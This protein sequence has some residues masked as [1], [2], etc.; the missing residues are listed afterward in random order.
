MVFNG[1]TVTSAGSA[2]YDVMGNGGTT[3]LGSA[4]SVGHDLTVNAGTFTTSASNY[5]LTIAGRLSIVGT[6]KLN[7]SVVSVGGDVTLSGTFNAGTSTVTMNGSGGQALGGPSAMTFYNLTANDPAG[8]SLAANLTVSNVLMLSSGPI[9]VG[10]HTLTISNPLGGTITNLVADGTSS[11]TVLGASPGIVVPSSVVQLAAL[12]VNN[13]NGVG[14]QANLDILGTLTLT[15]GP[16]TTAAF[17]LRVDVAGTV[18]R[19]AG[20]VNGYLQ[21]HV[22]TGA[23]VTVT[24]EIGDAASYTPVTVAF[25]VVT[26]AG[27]L[28][29]NTTPG[30]HPMIATSGLAPTRDVNRFWTLTNSGIA[31]DTY[32]ATFSFVATDVDAGANTAAFVVAKF[33]PGGWTLPAVGTRT[34]VTTQATGMTSFSDFA[35]G[36]GTADLGVTIDDGQTSVTAGTGGHA[37]TIT[38]TNGGPS[39][40][41][42]ASLSVT[43]PAG[44]SQGAVS[45][46]QGT[47][48]PVGAGPDLTCALGG[49]AAGAS[50]TVTI[51]YSVPAA[52]PAG[53][54]TAAVAVSGPTADLDGANDAASDATDVVTAADL[55]V[56][57]TD[58]L[59]SVAAGTGGYG[60]TIT[61]TNGGP[62]DA[63][64][65]T[66][67][68][69]WPAGF[70]Q[71]AVSPSQGTC[72]P[73]GA[74]PDLSC[75][76]GPLAAGASATVTIPYSVPAATP[77]GPQTVAVAVGSA[78]ADLDGANDAASDTTM[79]VTVAPLTVTVTDGQ[80]SVTAG[81][82]GYAYTITVTNGGPSDAHGVVL[83]DGV[84]GAFT[85]GLPSADLGGDCSGSVGN[86]VTCL[87]PADLA[88]GATWTISVPYAVAPSVLPQTVT[89]TVLATSA[90]DPAGQTASDATD[91][92][93]AADLGVTV[94]D[95][96]ASVAAGTG[97]YGYTITVTN[98]GPS[99]AAAV[100][101]SVSWP[102]GF[103]Q[104]A[105][106]PSQGTCSPVGAG[107]D[108]SCALGPLAAGAS[109]TVTIPYSVPAATPAGPQTV[110]VAVGSATAD[111]D[112][113]NDAAS[114]TTVVVTVAPSPTPRS[115]ASTSPTRSTTVTLPAS[116]SATV[117][118][119][120]GFGADPGGP[121]GDARCDGGDPAGH[122][123]PLPA[124]RA[125]PDRSGGDYAMKWPG[126]VPWRRAT[127]SV[128]GSPV[129]RDRLGPGVGGAVSWPHGV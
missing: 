58:G 30:E 84:P 116:D 45:P 36:E 13:A 46:S 28:T 80:A 111:L 106:S 50:A 112:G 20:R 33:D 64:A 53:T 77:A 67:S 129:T 91:V 48:S 76:L 85:V 63:A 27:E 68:V 16:V 8:V 41:A 23:G 98:G 26:T 87:L 96:L 14:L 113:A 47:C 78:T 3:T 125:R 6:L 121:H 86:T 92:V 37:Y 1:S 17:T 72:S 90:E 2:F 119:A 34:P 108:L 81:T 65:V 51:A 62:S 83:D 9:T 128:S 99:D 49:L 70:S 102:A 104:G 110:A 61:V 12:T 60:Y 120:R 25:G 38:V 31:F 94:T 71:G 42:G 122:T 7:G 114:D 101:L 39:D 109:A 32:S 21:K 19:T 10:A 52:T 29:A 107:P 69:S 5:G 35:L 105:V 56:T 115:S 126:A 18:T 74:G 4:M 75:A 127:P 11:I 59:A 22:P 55:G 24:Y 79:V 88:P 95:G 103:S 15:N 93:T 118:R 123:S 57:V 97:G 43:W 54:Q 124:L 44:F 100:T 117:V 40:A 66:L 73:V 89:D 82:G